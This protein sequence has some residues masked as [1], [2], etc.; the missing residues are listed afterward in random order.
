MVKVLIK[1][2]AKTNLNLLKS[3]M[4]F[5]ISGNFFFGQILSEKNLSNFFEKSFVKYPFNSERNF[6]VR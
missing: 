4:L 3:M 6:D 2:G 5:T 1:F